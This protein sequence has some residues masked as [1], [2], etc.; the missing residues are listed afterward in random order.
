M[1]IWHS[2]RHRVILYIIR[3]HWTGLAGQRMFQLK[4]R[5]HIKWASF[6]YLPRPYKKCWIEWKRWHNGAGMNAHTLNNSLPSASQIDK[7]NKISAIQNRIEHVIIC[8][9]QWWKVAVKRWHWCGQAA[10]NAAVAAV[11]PALAQDDKTE[12]REWNNKNIWRTSELLFGN[13]ENV[14][15]FFRV[16]AERYIGH[17]AMVCGIHACHTVSPI[18]IYHTSARA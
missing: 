16:H 5:C 18:Y 4:W 3:W 8:I 17:M 2:F 1:Y 15:P 10:G 11:G 7:V 14:L 13:A 9:V 12:K 6:F